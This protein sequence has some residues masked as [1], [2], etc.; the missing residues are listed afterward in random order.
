MK[1]L[2]GRHSKEGAAATAGRIRIFL[3]AAILLLAVLMIIAGST[4]GEM[5]LIY[6]KAV[7]ICLECIGIG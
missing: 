7:T 3:R 1:S 6:R 4:S 5:Q 2:T